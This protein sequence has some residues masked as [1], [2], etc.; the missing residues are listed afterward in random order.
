MESAKNMSDRLRDFRYFLEL[1]LKDLSKTVGYSLWRLSAYERGESAV[2]VALIA[3][4]YEKYKLNPTWLIT[5]EGEMI[6]PKE[7]WESG[8]RAESGELLEL[9]RVVE[10]V[11]QVVAPYASQAG[12]DPGGEN[13]RLR[14]EI[15]ALKSQLAAVAKVLGERK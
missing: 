1:S 11:C 2:P 6:L 4:L 14:A 8:E 9:R 3:N 5:G 12:V 15:E 13:A 10:A 7:R